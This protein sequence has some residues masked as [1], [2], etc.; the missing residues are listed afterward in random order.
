MY[1]FE[2]EFR[3]PKGTKN[4]RYEISPF[5]P[6]VSGITV[7]VAI[8]E[9]IGILLVAWE[10]NGQVHGQSIITKM[11]GGYRVF[12][13][14]PA[15]DALS[16]PHHSDLA[17]KALRHVTGKPLAKMKVRRIGRE[18]GSDRECPGHPNAELILFADVYGVESPLRCAKCFGPVPLYTMPR[19]E[20]GDQQD[21]T[22]WES[23]YRACYELQGRRRA[24]A[25]DTFAQN[26]LE[27][28]ESELSQSGLK[29]CAR[30]AEGT[31]RRTWY[32][33]TRARGLS[34]EAERERRCPRC[35]GERLLPECWHHEFDF[36]CERCGL[37]SRLSSAAERFDDEVAAGKRAPPDPDSP[38]M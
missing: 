10:I 23:A 37:L 1:V 36:R 7:A 24:A 35:G 13:R 21:I 17:R 28:P 33:L 27:N 16:E 20:R 38:G 34:E 9:T 6:A 8:K 18:A 31:G 11:P 2:L 32:Y 29:I 26:E 12:V 3:W 14:A 19:A 4:D 5:R 30:L 25:T 15:K 22:Y